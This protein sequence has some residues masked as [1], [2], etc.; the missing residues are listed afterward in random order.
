M[1]PFQRIGM[2]EVDPPGVNDADALV[3]HLGVQVDGSPSWI[4]KGD[5]FLAIF[6][7]VENL[8]L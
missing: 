1:I 4:S 8:T 6:I 7:Q 3:Q 2:F 5:S